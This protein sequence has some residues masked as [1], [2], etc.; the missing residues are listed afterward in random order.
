VDQ[1]NYEN[2]SGISG[3]TALVVSNKSPNLFNHIQQLNAA[4]ETGRQADGTCNNTK[5]VNDRANYLTNQK[6]GT[7]EFVYNTNN[8]VLIDQTDPNNNNTVTATPL[9]NQ[10]AAKVAAGLD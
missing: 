6:N 2:A 10:A 3:N 1:F 4:Q 5:V 9:L 8:E 7:G